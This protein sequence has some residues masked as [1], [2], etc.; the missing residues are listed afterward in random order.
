MSVTLTLTSAAIIAGISIA[1]ATSMA[2]I[3][4]VSDG[5]FDATEG[6]DTTFMDSEILLKTLNEYDCHFEAISENH[7]LVK[8]TCGNIIY[9]RDNVS[10]PFKMYLDEIDDVEGL[11]E[12]LKSF[13]LDYGRN[14]QSYTYNH[15]KEN[16][17]KNMSIVDEEVLD[18]DSL[19]L[20]IS[21]ED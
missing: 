13:E 10:Q 9:S 20:T 15:I 2:V 5:V 16:L 21:V 3:D 4:Q 17:G 11:L 14:V 7:Y 19:M 1:T 6:I 12:N 18:D 8:T